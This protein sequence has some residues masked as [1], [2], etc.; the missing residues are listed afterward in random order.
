MLK[1]PD[2]WENPTGEY[3]IGMKSG[4]SVFAGPLIKRVKEERKKKWDSEHRK[5]ISELQQ[6]I[7]SF[8]ET[9]PD[10]AEE[11]VAEL[12]E[13]KHRLVE[14]NKYEKSYEDVGPVYDCVV[15]HDGTEWRA[16]VDTTEK[17]ELSKVKL[18]RDYKV[19]QQYGTFGDVDRLNYGL[20]IYNDGSLLSI[21]TDSSSHG[22]HVAGIVGAYFPED[23]ELNGVA[24]GCQIISV[25]IG[26]MR[27]DSLETGTGL[28]RALKVAV[29]SKCDLINMSYGEGSAVCNAGEFMKLAAEVVDKHNIMY[30]SSAGNAGPALSSVGAP[31]G[32]SNEI[33]SVGAHVTPSAMEVEYSLRSKLP[34]MQFTFTS[35]GPAMDGD[36]G[37][38]ISAPGCAITSMPN[39]T[40]R[41]IS[42]KNGTSMAS[43][44]ACGSFAVLLSGLKTQNIPY[45]PHS[46]RRAVENTC[47]TLACEDKTTIGHGLIQIDKAYDNIVA[48]CK[49]Q[50][51]DVKFE[52]SLPQLGNGRG[53]YLREAHMTRNVTVTPVQVEPVFH[54]DADNQLKIDFEMRLKLKCDVEWV[55]MAENFMVMH[56][57]RTFEIRVDPVDLK[58]GLHLTEIVAYNSAS[59]TDG[60]VFRVPISV[61]KP[62]KMVEGSSKYFFDDVSFKPGH[63]ER[64]FLEVP[65]K[66][67][68][69]N[70]TVK[71]LDM[72]SVRIYAV[73]LLQ[74]VKDSRYTDYEKRAYLHM[75]KGEVAERS[76]PVYPGV[77]ME[78]AIEQYWS[79]LGSGR[80]SIEVEFRG[81]FCYNKELTMFGGHS[82]D[83]FDVESPF[84]KEVLL[85]TAKLQNWQHFLRPNSTKMA[86]IDVERD[87][88]SDAR[89]IFEM[90]ISYNLSLADTY[91]VTLMSPYLNDSLYESAF[92][93]Q[94][95]CV[96]DKNNC[97]VAISDYR[98]APNKL[99]KGSYT[100]TLMLR[101]HNL[102][103]LET[104]KSWPLIANL[105]LKTPL[106]VNVYS[107][108]EN[109]ACG[110]SQLKERILRAGV[111]CPIF[112]RLPDSAKLPKTAKPGDVLTGSITFGKQNSDASGKSYRPGGFPLKFVVCAHASASTDTTL[113]A[114]EKTETKP[115]DEMVFEK[116]RDHKITLLKSLMKDCD[117]KTYDLYYSGLKEEYGEYLHLSYAHLLALD[118]A[119]TRLDDLDEIIDVADENV[120]LIDQ[121]ELALFFGSRI[122][123]EDH[124][125]LKKKDEMVKTKN[126]LIDSLVK[127]G[128]A[129][130]DHMKGEE[131]EEKIVA[132][133]DNFKMLTKWCD[134]V[135]S[136]AVFLKMNYET[137][138]G[139]HGN[140]LN[141]LRSHVKT[142]DKDYGVLKTQLYEKLGWG[143]IAQ[144]EHNAVLV[145]YPASQSMTF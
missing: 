18:L 14:L 144:V 3:H 94:L 51:R 80:I 47:K 130:L 115:A 7:T 110:G 123:E 121:N 129:I 92:H 77:L 26:D 9:N 87:L 5:A 112:L 60:P 86:P 76:H 63:K 141:V 37:V 113:K 78:L 49:N 117:R 29:D 119:K 72:D 24:P 103:L 30:L 36:F 4:F 65:E 138:L 91:D 44:N 100:V 25:R 17:G 23:R 54:D 8:I 45:S 132:F 61:I 93:S 41:S 137:L 128:K 64:F 102:V 133:C 90:H 15:F 55:S 97:R 73:H 79:S 104:M 127:K 114:K 67:T 120:K 21:V 125:M 33:I 2:S 106:T 84:G 70:V 20:K 118:D 22:T 56:E 98:P 95:I 27:S 96:F 68:W 99:E 75:N 82:F 42:R 109:A 74:L 142:V 89:Q 53:I 38:D 52:V 16:A 12:K 31:G 62:H 136:K 126:I 39:W 19:D 66:A 59:M 81:I 58:P 139:R 85:P 50:E 105:K 134:G 46:I 57:P 40:L 11:Q 32:T 122:D 83:R 6:S 135:D 107:S 140:A 28:I 48:T 143:H 13:L 145:K 43:P 35:C 124:E 116:T 88:L 69:V 71:G 101:H 131:N 34:P 111:S 108:S 10:P 1:I